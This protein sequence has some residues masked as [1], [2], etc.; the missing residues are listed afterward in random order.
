M[1]ISETETIIKKV[2]PYLERRGYDGKAG[3]N[4]Q[5]PPV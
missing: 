4:N 1:K 3:I 5:P 2:L